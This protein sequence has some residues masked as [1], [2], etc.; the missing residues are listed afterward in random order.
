M[1]RIVL[2][3]TKVPKAGAASE[4]NI[5]MTAIV[6]IN[7]ISVKPRICR[8]DGELNKQKEEVAGALISDFMA[9]LSAAARLEDWRLSAA[10][11]RL[12]AKI[13]EIKR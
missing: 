6:T 10:N 1:L 8:A 4:A 13:G 2:R 5:A 12:S 7:S 9:Q 11:D 3:V